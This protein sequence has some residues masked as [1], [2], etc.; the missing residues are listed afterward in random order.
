[1]SAETTQSNTDP[2]TTNNEEVVKQEPSHYTPV[3]APLFG[4]GGPNTSSRPKTGNTGISYIMSHGSVKINVLEF[5]PSYAI[6]IL[7]I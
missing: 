1:M 4:F 5:H 7:N 2:G 3:R 6:P